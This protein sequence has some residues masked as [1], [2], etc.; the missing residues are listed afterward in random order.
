VTFGEAGP[1][2]ATFIP[3]GRVGK[4]VGNLTSMMSG[5]GGGG[6]VS[7]E[8]LLSPDLESRIVA[9]TLGQ[10]ADVIT[11]IIRSK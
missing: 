9:N 5:G 6:K 4:N 7:I 11:K 2:L 8:L 3:L 1:E 10:T